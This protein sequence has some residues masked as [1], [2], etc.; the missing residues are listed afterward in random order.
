MKP[1]GWRASARIAWRD[2][3]GGFRGLRLL[4]ICLFLGVA[5]LAAIGSLT[6]SI[7]GELSARGQT[8]LGGD[9][10]IAMTQREA[11]R[12]ELAAMQEM[13]ELSET[14]RMR[15]MA[16]LADTDP[17]ADGPQAVL[18]E[19]KGV[20][21][22]Y[23]LYGDFVLQGGVLD[24]PLAPTEMVIGQ[25]LSDRLQIEP[26]ESLRYGT[27]TFIIRDVIADEPVG[28]W[29]VE[30][31]RRPVRADKPRP[32]DQYAILPGREARSIFADEPAAARDQHPRS[33]EPGYI[34]RD[35]RPGRAAAVRIDRGFQNRRYHRALDDGRRRVREPSGPYPL[36]GIARCLSARCRSTGLGRRGVYWATGAGP[37]IDKHGTG[38]SAPNRPNRNRI[39]RKNR[40]GVRGRGFRKNRRIEYNN[41]HRLFRDRLLRG[42]QFSDGRGR[43]VERRYAALDLHQRSDR[44]TGLRGRQSPSLGIERAEEQKCGGRQ[45]GDE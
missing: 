39:G 30:R 38:R 2:L 31:D 29:R 22:A 36:I 18:S 3:S 8:M 5:T 33:I 26:G 35:D 25:S 41:R 17:S 7:T 21:S 14:I 19:L 34:L 45:P 37:V 20:D 16:Q 24:E 28:R 10:E 13:G 9:V 4:F 15:A 23:P 44:R 11:D 27:A 43:D 40:A 12:D 32:F 42:A 1:L 6:A